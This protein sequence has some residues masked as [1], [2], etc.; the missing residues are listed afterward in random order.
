M[1]Y[2]E[3]VVVTLFSGNVYVLRENKYVDFLISVLL[4]TQL[5]RKINFG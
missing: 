3:L 1:L 2:K 4:D 5:E